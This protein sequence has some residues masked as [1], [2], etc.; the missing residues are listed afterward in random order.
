M[1][2]GIG[3]MLL[4]GETELVGDKHYTAS[5]VDGLLSMGNWWNYTDC[6]NRISGR[7]NYTASVVHE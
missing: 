7:K 3:G 4:P 1:S 6:R 5:V 2:R